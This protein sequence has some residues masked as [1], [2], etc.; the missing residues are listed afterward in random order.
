MF[1]HGVASLNQK[2]WDDTVE[3]GVIE[4]FQPDEIEEVFHM[5]R[6]VVCEKTDFNFPVFGGDDGLGIFLFELQGR[7]CRHSLGTLPRVC[8]VHQASLAFQRRGISKI[9][10]DKGENTLKFLPAMMSVCT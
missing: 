3:G 4:K 9:C 5:S 10:V 1:A 6:R 7:C 2:P 8:K